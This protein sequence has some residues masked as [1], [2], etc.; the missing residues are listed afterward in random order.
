LGAESAQSLDFVQQLHDARLLGEWREGDGET[1]E[2][3]FSKILNIGA[4][5]LGISPCH[6]AWTAQPIGAESWVQVSKA[7]D[8]AEGAYRSSPVTRQL[9]SLPNH[10][11]TARGHADSDIIALQEL[12]NTNASLRHPNEI[13]ACV[14]FRGDIARP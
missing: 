6:E 10:S 4:L 3:R 11:G 14:E 12:L 7:N 9:S 1:I 5:R 8:G 2:F 13:I